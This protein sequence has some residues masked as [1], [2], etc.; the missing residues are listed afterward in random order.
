MSKVILEENQIIKN[1]E[2]SIALQAIVFRFVLA[3]FV[4]FF[5]MLL[6]WH[7]EP[8]P[9]TVER[10]EGDTK[11]SDCTGRTYSFQRV[12][13]SSK[14]INI[15][16]QERWHDLDGMMDENIIE[17]EYVIPKPIHYPLGEDFNKVMTFRKTVPRALGV[18]VYEYRPWATYQVN[19][20]K[21]ITRLLPTQKVHVYC[22]YDPVK[23]GV[24][25]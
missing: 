18:G 20:I 2:R 23:H 12:V 17:G 24:M 5:L 1:M 8:D 3:A 6:Y 9:L 14:D 13:K 4:S 25:D 7:F 16:V 11:W 15:Y 22:E 10:L 21:T 19:P